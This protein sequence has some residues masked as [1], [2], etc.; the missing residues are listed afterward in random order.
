MSTTTARPVGLTEPAT[1]AGTANQI[2]AR[3][4]APNATWPSAA[5][6]ALHRAPASVAAQIRRLAADTLASTFTSWPARRNWS[7]S[8][9]A[10]SAAAARSARAATPS[11]SATAAPRAVSHGATTP[12]RM[13][14]AAKASAVGGCRYAIPATERTPS[15]SATRLGSRERTTRSPT[16]S[17]SAPTRASKSPRRNPNST[18]ASA[19]TS[20]RYTCSRSVAMPRSATSWEESRSR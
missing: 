16:A 14:Q 18:A 5:P 9:R 15:P 10:V 8:S 12:A 6:S 11:C 1:A 2:A 19:S 7:G 3:T 4:A 13:R 20:C 17:T